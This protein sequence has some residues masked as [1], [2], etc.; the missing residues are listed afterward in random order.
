MRRSV[1]ES[2]LPAKLDATVVLAVAIVTLFLGFSIALIN[3]A[4]DFVSSARSRTFRG[5]SSTGY[6]AWSETL[7]RLA[8]SWRL[9][10]S[11]LLDIAADE[12]VVLCEP[13][14]DAI[15]IE[16]VYLRRLRDWIESGGR[17][18]LAANSRRSAG[19]FEGTE[20]PP[21]TAQELL[22]AR[23]PILE[24]IDLTESSEEADRWSDLTEDIYEAEQA[25]RLLEVDKIGEWPNDLGSVHQVALHRHV[26]YLSGEVLD[27]AL[28]RMQVT[29]EQHSVD[30]A[31]AWKIGQGE[32][33]IVA[34]PRL[35]NNRL[36]GVADNALAA[37]A[38]V[39]GGRTP[40]A[41]EGFYQGLLK[42][43][44]PLWLFVQNG[45]AG[46]SMA[47]LLLTLIAVWRASQF[48]GPPIAPAAINRR[49]VREYLDSLSRLYLRTRGHSRFLLQTIR[50]G[51]I[52]ELR[53]RNHLP[54]AGS[55][56]D[57]LL[58]RLHRRD[59]AHAE[60]VRAVII[61]SER[62]EQAN[63]QDHLVIPAMERLRRCL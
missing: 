2:L 63:P 38:L 15:K 16:P 9:S 29:V 24:Q 37:V 56:I 49:S 41:F 19:L 46:L 44:Q 12:I 1:K 35:F 26:Q 23:A 14:E 57:V 32:L 18:V 7:H 55:Q 43:G 53:V 40:V 10:P 52:E 54:R 8:P 51:V 47:V 58:Q 62:L 20:P 25:P 39:G 21:Q 17:L 28:W 45:Y 13:D 48:L 59:P 27:K 60:V 4:G 61:E 30:I 5:Y 42:R 3:A 50:G 33:T 6:A 11:P 31:A 22:M 36:I 34:D